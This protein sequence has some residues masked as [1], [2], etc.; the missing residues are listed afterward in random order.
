[1]VAT[2]HAPSTPRGWPAAGRRPAARS[3]RTLHHHIPRCDGNDGI[4]A[5][6]GVNLRSPASW[7]E[8]TEYCRG[9]RRARGQQARAGGRPRSPVL[10]EVEQTPQSRRSG[11]RTPRWHE[12][13]QGPERASP[14]RNERRLDARPAGCPPQAEA[15]LRGRNGLRT[16]SRARRGGIVQASGASTRRHPL[17]AVTQPTFTLSSKSPSDQYRSIASRT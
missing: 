5:N 4:G 13:E 1:L 7:A 11:P 9:R 2:T 15:V 6:R 16:G 12:W 17:R 3:A 8:I 14:A 10:R